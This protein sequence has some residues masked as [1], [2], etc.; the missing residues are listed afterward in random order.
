MSEIQNDPVFGTQLPIGSES[1]IAIERKL[2][3]IGADA[4]ADEIV[5]NS[6]TQSA[7]SFGAIKRISS[8]FRKF[9]QTQHV[10][11]FLAGDG[12]ASIVSVNDVRPNQDLADKKLKITLD[13]L[14]VA[15]YPG[16]GEHTILFDFALQAQGCENQAN[17]AFHYNAKFSAN[18]GETV[19][20]RNYPLFSGINASSEG[21]VFG[22]QTINVSSSFQDGLLDFLD[23]NEFRNGLTILGAMTP[24]LAQISEITSSLSR[25]LAKQ[26]EN[27]KV[28]EFLQGLDFSSSRVGGGLA[29]GTYIVVQIPQEVQREW[30]WEDWIV[31]PHLLRLTP[32]DNL[33]TPVDY[34][35]MMFGVRSI[36]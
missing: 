7:D 26:T 23:R 18:N 34:N 13:G 28:Q 14:H 2:R 30:S 20:V 8:M 16:H 4:L 19:P 25:W 5:A 17:P 6:N 31:D 11:G 29:E 36:E 27:V 9:T 35:H 1:T 32:K 33:S 3:A 21:I 15:C 12:D 22:F 10:C 24:A